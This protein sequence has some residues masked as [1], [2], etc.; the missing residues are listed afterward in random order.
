MANGY[1]RTN[2]G[3]ITSYTAAQLAAMALAGE[4]TTDASYR[5]SNTGARYH[6]DDPYTL[7]EELDAVELPA[8]KLAVAEGLATDDPDTISR[9]AG[10]PPS[11]TELVALAE[12]TC[13]PRPFTL[14]QGAAY[15]TFT[16]P[17]AT[18]TS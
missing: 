13:Y 12:A 4:L 9:K 1:W 3:V 8:V 10:L 6:A 5:A 16:Q 11:M 2:G 17:A 15:G 7:V 14:Y 18:F